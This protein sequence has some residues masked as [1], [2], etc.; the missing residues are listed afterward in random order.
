MPVCGKHSCTA[1]HS[2]PG[3]CC[4]SNTQQKQFAGSSGNRLESR[5]CC[6]AAC[7]LYS[8]LKQQAVCLAVNT[9]PTC[10]ST[11]PQ[12]CWAAAAAAA[13][14]STG[15]SS[16]QSPR[17]ARVLAAAVCLLSDSLAGRP[18]GAGIAHM[19]AAGPQ[20]A[21]PAMAVTRGECTVGVPRCAAA[22]ARGGP[23]LTTHSSA[24]RKQMG[25]QLWGHG[26]LHTTTM[27]LQP[28]GNT[29]RGQ[30]AAAT[31]RQLGAGGGQSDQNLKPKP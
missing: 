14:R 30:G 5:L 8:P 12:L 26:Q 11:H 20:G 3:P 21:A 10:P 7:S 16:A 24:A 27:W 19:Q 22:R 1:S 25:L 17:A 18:R 4:P 15:S 23:S 9:C 13:L 28:G 31:H 29:G 6:S 2:I